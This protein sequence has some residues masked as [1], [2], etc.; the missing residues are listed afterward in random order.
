MIRLIVV[1]LFVLVLNSCKKEIP[2]LKTDIKESE[3]LIKS[4][5]NYSKDFVLGKFNYKRD[6]GFVKVDP[7]YSSKSIYLNREVYEAFKRMYNSAKEE[8]V[9][10][11][12]I[13]GTRSFYE[14]K[15]IWERKWKKYNKYRPIERAK[16][17][18]EYSSMPTTSRH[19][20]G[21]DI[22]LNNL[23][24][25]YFG[26]GKGLREYE[27]LLK[28]GKLYGFYQVYTS[29]GN[30]RTGY[31]QEKW[32]WSYLPLASKYLSYLND[33][34]TYSDIVGFKGSEL[35]EETRILSEY[36]NGVSKEVGDFEKEILY[37]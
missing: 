10:L 3:K 1:C 11:N 9:E 24:N 17:I 26:K 19:H 33:N 13:S 5:F 30:G 36:V 14:Q 28:N 25:S 18:L 35:A 16:K 37:E 2:R 4:K 23:N 12:I 6:T 31:N 20:W 15:F 21:T 7:K 29:K 34:I 8:G 32:H 27:W 22:D